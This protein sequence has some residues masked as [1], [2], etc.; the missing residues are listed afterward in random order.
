MTNGLLGLESELMLTDVEGNIVNRAKEVLESPLNIGNLVPE[1]SQAMVEINPKPSAELAKLE[2]NLREELT[3]LERIA[4]SKGLNAIPLSEIGPG[5]VSK[6][7]EGYKRYDLYELA[8]G[9]LSSKADASACGTHLH[10]DHQNN[11]VG[12]FNLYQSMDPV[13]AFMSS[14]SFFMGSNSV[15]C[16]RVNFFRNNIFSEH[17]FMTQLLDYVESIEDIHELSK[18][19]R[20]FFVER[21]GDSEEIRKTFSG[22]KNGSTPIRMTD[23]TIEIRATDSNLPTLSMAMAALYKGV[24]EY[25]FGNNLDIRIAD[26]DNEYGITSKE[27]L[28]PNYPTL[29]QMESAAIREGPQAYIV[30]E[31]LSHLVGIAEKGLPEEE[32]RYLTPFKE[33]LRTKKNIAGL[34]LE[35]VGKKCDHSPGQ[36]ESDSAR[37]V[38]RFIRELYQDDLTGGNKAVYLIGNGIR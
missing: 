7:I 20:E 8:T 13:F 35:F 23:N 5:Q 3:F 37:K 9:K 18:K 32:R 15:N 26:R 38:N 14:T 2:S 6:R 4:E 28:L 19:R 27:I 33:V 16:G 11:L 22:H 30:N 29:K 17:P 34:V 21:L 12:Q 10:I 31:Y 24:T 1:Y 36:L 25:V